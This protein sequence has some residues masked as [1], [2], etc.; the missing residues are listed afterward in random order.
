LPDHIG[1]RKTIRYQ[2]EATAGDRVVSK[3]HHANARWRFGLHQRVLG[4]PNAVNDIVKRRVVMTR[5][6]MREFS[7]HGAVADS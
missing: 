4:D 2:V 5:L 1:H 7:G 3:L 6:E